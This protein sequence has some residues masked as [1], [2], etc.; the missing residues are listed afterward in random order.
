MAVKGCMANLKKAGTDT[1]SGG[2]PQWNG[3]L[4]AS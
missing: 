3:K 1:T 4:S 2:K